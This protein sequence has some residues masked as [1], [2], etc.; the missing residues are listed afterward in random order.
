LPGT[1]RV[2]DAIP[3]DIK[4]TPTDARYV[5]RIKTQVTFDKRL[6]QVVEDG[7]TSYTPVSVDTGAPVSLSG[8]TLTSAQ[9]TTNTLTVAGNTATITLDLDGGFVPEGTSPVLVGTFYVRPLQKTASNHEIRFSGT[10][11][12]QAGEK[13]ATNA[14]PALDF[15]VAVTPAT[16]ASDGTQLADP[17]IGPVLGTLGVSLEMRSPTVANPTLAADTV[18]WT[19]SSSSLDVVDG[20]FLD[21]KVIV[22]AKSLVGDARKVDHLSI[23]LAF[24]ASQLQ[25]GDGTSAVANTDYKL[26]TDI[27]AGTVA[28][29]STSVTLPLTYTPSSSAFLSASTEVARLR[30]KLLTPATPASATVDLKVADSTVLKQSTGLFV[31]DNYADPVGAG[32]RGEFDASPTATRQKPATLQISALLQGRTAQNDPSR[33]VQNFAIEL[34]ASGAA[35]ARHLT[36]APAVSVSGCTASCDPDMKFVKA[37]K[38]VSSSANAQFAASNANNAAASPLSDLEPGTY[39]VYVKGRSSVAVLVKD[40]VFGAGADK[41]IT[42]LVMA[43]GDLD[44][45]D[46][47]KTADFTAFSSA[48]RTEVAAFLGYTSGTTLNVT[49]VL[50]GNLAV[51]Q[52]LG[53]DAALAGIT[54]NAA[55]SVDS[56]GVGTYTLSAAPTSDVGTST[57]PVVL[58]ASNN[59]TSRVADMNQSGYVD[60]LDFSLLGY[61]YDVV[62][63]TDAVS[64]TTNLGLGS[65]NLVTVNRV[66]ARSS[67]PTASLDVA[68]G[69][70][71]S[72]GI[73]A[74]SVAVAPGSRAV[75]G[76][77]VNLKTA[78]G[79]QV[80]DAPSGGTF[81]PAEANPMPIVLQ[82]AWDAARGLI[83]LGLGRAPSASGLTDP[84]T[85]GTIFVKI[86]AGFTG[87]PISI[88]RTDGLFPTTVASAGTDVTGALN[89]TVDGTTVSVDSGTVVV[90][91]PA[92]GSVVIGG[93]DPVVVASPPARVPASSGGA[94]ALT[95]PVASAAPVQASSPA[96]APASAP[97]SAARPSTT[98]PTRSPFAPVMIENRIKGTLTLV[99]PGTG[100]VELKTGLATTTPDAFCPVARHKTYIRLEDT[101]IAGATFGVEAGGVLSWVTPDQAGCVNWNAISEGGLTFTKETIMQFQLA[102]AVPGALLW[103]LDGNRNGE[104]YEVDAQGVA[105]YVTADAFAANQDHFTEVWANVIPVSTSQIEGLSARGSVHR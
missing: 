73:A 79:V 33:F 17:A 59:Q 21:V 20:R 102:Q 24:D 35:K 54:I 57:A 52:S 63:P 66:G 23:V 75:D 96:V 93:S 42:N 3:V 14:T 15:E 85:L 16:S 38:Q 62:G 86:P 50:R 29:A 70:R 98:A 25:L 100:T 80:V 28:V 101:G 82:Q 22:D 49:R 97:A 46:Q 26:G 87:S 39:D 78:P 44:G 72:D 11:A 89:V 84:T 32:P 56:N 67:N 13:R 94:P 88:E 104:L 4:I 34:R 64:G 7:T 12:S 10:V 51:G 37:S 99:R 55:G 41:T 43:E 68:V 83:N 18:T 48:Y 74:V 19:A 2:G 95:A 31:T 30:F 6:F 36:V 92:A 69:P 91:Q 27:T 81:A 9:A 90:D 61:N 5:N 45:N 1:I 47:V 40:V 76:V 60:I 58:W 103:V 53:D 105:N 65:G 8:S 71:D 77:Q